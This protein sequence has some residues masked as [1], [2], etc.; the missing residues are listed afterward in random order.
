[1]WKL[2]DVFKK[3]KKKDIVG[4]IEERKDMADDELSIRSLGRYAFSSIEKLSQIVNRR[5]GSKESR[6]E[7]MLI[8]S[9]YEEEGSNVDIAEFDLVS[10]LGYLWPRY[11]F[12]SLCILPLLFLI[13]LPYLGFV[14]FVLVS[15]FSYVDA[16]S[17]KIVLE[18]FRKK[19]KGVNLEVR[20]EP[21][22]KIVRT[23]ILSAHHDSARL[24]TRKKHKSD[25]VL[26]LVALA[27]DGIISIL[28]SIIE[29]AESR[30]FTFNLPGIASLIMILI[31]MVLAGASYRLWNLY[32]EECSPGVGDNLSGEG[33]LL[34]LHRYF[35]KLR[36]ESTRLIFT[37]FDAEEVGHQGARAYY[38]KLGLDY[39]TININV[40]GLYGK[41]ELCFL[42]LD[43]NGSVQLS[44]HLASELVHTAKSLGYP[45]KLGKLPFLGG[46][47]D[48]MAASLKGYKATTLSGMHPDA[49]TPGHTRED[50]LSSVEEETLRIAVEILVKYI[51][52]IDLKDSGE[53]EE[54]KIATS[55]LDS[56]RH[57]KLSLYDEN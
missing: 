46:S 9:L 12:L 43:G 25:L 49:R 51:Q 40:D 53:S 22:G 11:L 6:R 28:L 32:E 23:I 56:A 39:D 55:R 29:I 16:V 41:D 37:S 4:G 26:P 3:R 27:Y 30:F 18:K 20:L 24:L 13:G 52:K 44:S 19:E 57:Y 48:A 14:L 5:A 50:T 31:S 45:L 1:M 47:T 7:A 54:E 42:S 35:S 21:R 33:V 38:D 36:C 8:S 15:L 2:L 10:D 17:G 34:A